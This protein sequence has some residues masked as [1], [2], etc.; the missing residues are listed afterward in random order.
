MARFP[1]VAH[2]RRGGAGRGPGA[3][4]RTRI[5]RAG[6]QPPCRGAGGG[7]GARRALPRHPR[8]ARCPARDRAVHGGRDPR[9]SPS[10]SVSRFWTG[11]PSGCSPGTT[12]VAGWPGEPAVEKRLWSFAERHTPERRVGDYTQAVMDL[13]AMLCTPAR[14][15]SV[16]SL[17]GRVRLP[18]ARGG[19]SCRVPGAAAEAPLSHP[20]D[21]SGSDARP[22]RP[23]AR[24][25]TAAGRNLG[26]PSGAFPKLPPRTTPRGA[27][28]VVRQASPPEAG[29]GPRPAA[30]SS[31]ASPTFACG[32]PRS[33]CPSHP[34]RT[35]WRTEAPCAGSIPAWTRVRGPVRG[36]PPFASPEVGLAAAV[37][38]VLSRLE[39]DERENP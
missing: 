37:G 33:S 22:A 30:G 34:R 14:S 25:A 28:R 35:G 23:G 26:G 6:P 1:D 4:E 20:R 16:S 13:G 21:A 7:G 11:T 15:R 10:G 17:S 31:T 5:L 19:R 36:A 3:V 32:R 18:G 27:R 29:A 8:R 24:R 39:A 9:P 38:T 12:R 2:A